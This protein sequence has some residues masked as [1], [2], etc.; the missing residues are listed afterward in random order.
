MGADHSVDLHASAD[1]FL[2]QK[3]AQPPGCIISYVRMPG[4]DGVT[5]LD[6]L[7]DSPLWAPVILISGH[8]DVPMA[9]AA[10]KNGAFDFIEK[11]IDDRKLVASINRALA[12]VNQQQGETTAR[13][14]L[15]SRFSK[16]TGREVEVFDLI[17]AGLTNF[18]VG[19]RLGI[20][21][22]TV[23]SYR[24]QIMSKMQA[25]GPATLVRQAIRLNRLDP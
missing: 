11:P 4:L 17:T 2:S 10:I 9:V 7:K 14:D 18:G 21:V 12:L 23:E 24:A 19:D 8:A 16:L 5:F 6:H 1:A 22:R 15:Q 13:M 25:D 3:V 20:S